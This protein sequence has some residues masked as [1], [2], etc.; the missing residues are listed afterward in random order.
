MFTGEYKEFSMSAAHF[1]PT[2]LRT[3]VNSYLEN[4]SHCK[5]IAFRKSKIKC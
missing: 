1:A 2:I 3:V 5:T 4:S